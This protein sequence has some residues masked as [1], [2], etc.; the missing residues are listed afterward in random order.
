MTKTISTSLILAV[1][2]LSLQSCQFVKFNSNLI[3]EDGKFINGNG[4]VLQASD[5]W[6]ISTYEVEDFTG[7]I[8]TIPSDIRYEMTD[9]AATVE[10][11]AP[12]N[13]LEHMQFS[14]VNGTLRIEYDEP[15]RTMVGGIKIRVCSSALESLEMKGAGDFDADSLVSKNL[16]VLIHG[17]GGVGLGT[18]ECD[19]DFSVTIQGAGDARVASLN[20]MKAEGLIQGAG[21]I[22]IAGK[23]DNGKFKIQGAGEIHVEQ[24]FVA[25]EISTSVQGVGRIY[26]PEN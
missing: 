5:E 1:A 16:N 13:Y 15:I 24:L 22:R 3:N 23:A 8:S 20:C 12:D 18:V 25:E 7:I 6:S 26:R 9:S 21:D 17:A 10:I 4:L 14:S 11:W 19:G 2:L